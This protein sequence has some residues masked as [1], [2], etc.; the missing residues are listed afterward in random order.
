MVCM[1]FEDLKQDWF[2]C[3]V[4]LVVLVIGW[5]FQSKLVMCYYFDCLYFEKLLKY[6]CVVFEMF[7]IIVYWQFVMC[8]DIEEICGVMVNMQVVK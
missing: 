2:G 3:G 1:L 6:L 8:G 7:V 5:C 4:E